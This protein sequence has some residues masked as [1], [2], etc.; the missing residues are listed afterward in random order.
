MNQRFVLFACSLIALLGCGAERRA[1]P[2]SGNTLS[3]AEILAIYDQVNSFDVAT[4]ALGAQRAAAPEVRALA[5]MVREDHTH[6]RELTRG[7][8]DELGLELKLPAG[9]EQAA[10]DHEDALAR[11]AELNGAAFDR[12]YLDY[13]IR[14]HS[15]AI[16]AVKDVLMPAA[17]ERVRKLMADILPGFEHHLTETER[18]ARELGVDGATPG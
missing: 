14:F 9:R 16:A 8:A 11:L 4:G 13:E 12:A 3:D 5:K 2:Q 18:L 10:S 15:D 6:V 17:S 1:E 7:L